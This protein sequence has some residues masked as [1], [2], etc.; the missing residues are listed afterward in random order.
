MPL[1]SCPKNDCPRKF[2]GHENLEAHLKEHEGLLPFVCSKC[3]KG[4]TYKFNMKPHQKKCK[5]PKRLQRK[6]YSQ[7]STCNF[8]YTILINVIENNENNNKNNNKVVCVEVNTH[9]L[10]DV[11]GHNSSSSSY[12][13][14]CPEDSCDSDYS[15]SSDTI[16]V[17]R[18]VHIERLFTQSEL[19]NMFYQYRRDINNDGWI[20]HSMKIENKQY[21]TLPPLK[22]LKTLLAVD[23]K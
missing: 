19:E 15:E 16:V 23:K 9:P 22:Y 12:G 20:D 4:F 21:L 5:G 7:E 1:L 6:P 18:K 11:F 8:N 17:E 14:S 3:N 2:N 13:S 10:L